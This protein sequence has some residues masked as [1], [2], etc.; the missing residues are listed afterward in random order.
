MRHGGEIAAFQQLMYHSGMN[1]IKEV[2][3]TDNVIEALKLD[4]D[5]KLTRIRTSVPKFMMKS[6]QEFAGLKGSKIDNKFCAG[7]AKYLAFV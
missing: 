5:R 4:H 7:E 2:D 6:F 3:I 1:A